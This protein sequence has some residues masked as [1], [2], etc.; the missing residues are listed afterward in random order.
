MEIQYRSLDRLD[1]RYD[2]SFHDPLFVP[3]RPPN[4]TF[5]ELV[6]IYWA[7]LSEDYRQNDVSP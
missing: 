7:E 4:T 5:G 1:H 3:E 6:E 2:R